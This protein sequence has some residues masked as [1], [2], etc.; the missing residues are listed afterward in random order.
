MRQ[1]CAANYAAL[2][3]RKWI[4]VARSSIQVQVFGVAIHHQAKDKP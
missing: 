4:A 1:H 3:I 2:R